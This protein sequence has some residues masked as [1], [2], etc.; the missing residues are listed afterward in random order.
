MC[1]LDNFRR[2]QAGV[3]I[4]RPRPTTTTQV[5]IDNATRKFEQD[6]DVGLFIRR[7]RHLAGKKAKSIVDPEAYQPASQPDN[8]PSPPPPSP[9]APAPSP[10][11]PSPPAPAS[12]PVGGAR[13]RVPLVPPPSQPASTRPHPHA[14]EHQGAGS[15]HAKS[16]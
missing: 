16:N 8:P 11:P 1:F 2:H 14:Q 7:C 15:L 6:G 3:R 9:P 13:P 5:L 12:Q 4:T 10:P